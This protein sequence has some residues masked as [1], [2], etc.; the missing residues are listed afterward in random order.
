MA[1]LVFS[2]TLVGTKAQ[3]AEKNLT[4]LL[5]LVD[6]FLMSLDDT[7]VDV[8]R[9]KYSVAR[10]DGASLARTINQRNATWVFAE[11]TDFL[12]VMQGSDTVSLT[13]GCSLSSGRLRPNVPAAT[14]DAM[15]AKIDEITPGQVHLQ[16][17]AGLSVRDVTYSRTRP[18]RN[19]L[20]LD[21]SSI[22]DL[23]DRRGFYDDAQLR[24]IDKLRHAVLP[25]GTRRNIVG[26]LFAIDWS[27]GVDGHNESEIAKRLAARDRWLTDQ[28]IGATAEGWTD[29]GDTI[30]DPVGGRAHDELTLYSPAT[31][32]G[33]IAVHSAVS[34]SHRIK[35]LN[36]A[37]AMLTRGET[38]LGERICNVIVIADSRAAATAM[39]KQVLAAGLQTVV[40]ATD[41]HLLDPFPDGTWA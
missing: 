1:S 19:Y 11:A 37:S 22:V 20:V 21:A 13:G 8:G 3:A 2:V 12:D 17:M 29:E 31:A 30:V 36:K 7:K 6:K 24:T 34:D 28:G 14:F 32:V 38:T 4:A 25:P 23:V 5:E 33:Y 39:R 35:L 10:F 41:A 9:K 15:L 16:G 40:Y 26:D 18:P 27:G